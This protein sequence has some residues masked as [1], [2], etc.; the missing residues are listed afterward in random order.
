LVRPAWLSSS[1]TAPPF[2]VTTMSVAPS[3]SMSP[4]A[5]LR[6][7]W[8]RPNA[9]PPSALVSTKRPAPVLWKSRLALPPGGGVQEAGARQRHGGSGHGPE[10][11]AATHEIP[12]IRAPAMVVQRFQMP[13]MTRRC[14]CYKAIRYFLD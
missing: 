7:I 13:L 5:A 4:K 2:V 9:G 11:R 10:E 1:L 14:G 6:L 8:A 3:L 12:P